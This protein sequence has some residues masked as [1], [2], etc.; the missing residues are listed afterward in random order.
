MTRIKPVAD[1][2]WLM[3]TILKRPYCFIKKTVSILYLDAR[4][5]KKVSQ[6]RFYGKAQHS[7]VIF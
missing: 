3:P 6:N 4:N 5:K 7:F 1:T 2:W